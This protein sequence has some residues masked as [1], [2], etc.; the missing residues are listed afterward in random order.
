VVYEGLR[1]DKP[2]AQVRRETP[3]AKP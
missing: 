2:A 1:E 3:Y